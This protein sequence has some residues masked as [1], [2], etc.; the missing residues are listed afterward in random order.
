MSKQMTKRTEIIRA[1]LGIYNLP[2]SSDIG[3][4]SN[5]V[6]SDFLISD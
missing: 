6:I 2:Q 1:K 3:Q 5:W 4:N